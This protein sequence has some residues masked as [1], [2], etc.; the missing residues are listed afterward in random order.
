MQGSA[1]YS[2]STDRIIIHPLDPED[3]AIT[4][5]MRAM[6]S[7]AKGVPRGIEARGPFDALMEKRST[8]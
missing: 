7:S 3:G 8:A 4:S 5:A 1:N 2:P 6:V